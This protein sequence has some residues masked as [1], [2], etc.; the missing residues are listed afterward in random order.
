VYYGHDLRQLS[1]RSPFDVKVV[2][3]NPRLWALYRHVVH[4][5]TN[6]DLEPGGLLMVANVSP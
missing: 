2:V 4:H 3:N 5:M 6:N 1:S